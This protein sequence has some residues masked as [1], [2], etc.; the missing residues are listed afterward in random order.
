M[1][2]NV[3]SDSIFGLS[4]NLLDE[5]HDKKNRGLENVDTHIQSWLG[6]ANARL[7]HFSRLVVGVSGIFTYTIR[8]KDEFAAVLAHVTAHTFANHRKE[9]QRRK[10]ERC[11]LSHMVPDTSCHDFSP[12]RNTMFD[13]SFFCRNAL[14]LLLISRVKGVILEVIA[15][16]PRAFST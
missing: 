3:W 13:L 4:L 10:S 1:S 12:M 7:C 15:L 6:V 9:S 11:L 8:S 16:C 14:M 5:Q 2:C